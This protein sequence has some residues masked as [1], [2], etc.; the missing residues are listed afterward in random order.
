MAQIGLDFIEGAL[1]LHLGRAIIFHSPVETPAS[2]SALSVC[3]SHVWVFE[4]GVVG[5][6]KGMVV[7]HLSGLWVG[8]EWSSKQQDEGLWPMNLVVH[9]AARLLDS[10]VA[11]LFF[12]QQ[13]VAWHLLV[14]GSWEEDV[15]VLILV[16]LVLLRVL[17]FIGEVRHISNSINFYF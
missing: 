4:H 16:V 12:E 13:A 8:T 6:G 17:D 1:R 7:G 11:P 9:P 5:T 10:E 15:S 3:L 14:C 2:I